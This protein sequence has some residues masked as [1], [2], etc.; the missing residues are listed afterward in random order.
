[1]LKRVAVAQAHTCP[2]GW[3]HFDGNCY[4]YGSQNTETWDDCKTE[5]EQENAGM[6][7]IQ[8]S[9]QNAFVAAN[10]GDSWLG[11]S[12][13]AEE[14]T[15]VWNAGCESSLELWDAGPWGVRSRGMG[16]LTSCL[17]RL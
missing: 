8:D 17:K 6:L 12:D 11:L 7:C 2:D 14:G 10:F 3:L 4:A 15:W 1:M 9:A 5:C 13:V 16:R